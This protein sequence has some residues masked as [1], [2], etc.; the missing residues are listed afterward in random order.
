MFAINIVIENK[1]R[2]P[3]LKLLI[4]CISAHITHI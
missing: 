1:N 3:L 2:N 4:N